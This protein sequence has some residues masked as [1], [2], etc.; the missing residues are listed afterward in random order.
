MGA[1][2]GGGASPR[3]R[4]AP[5]ADG[6]GSPRR[7]VARACAAAPPWRRAAGALLVAALAAAGAA[8]IWRGVT[9][10]GGGG[11]RGP[12]DY[13]ALARE[14]ESRLSAPLEAGGPPCPLSYPRRSYAEIA[15]GAAAPWL[16]GG[17]ARDASRP[18]VNC[19]RGGLW[20]TWCGRRPTGIRNGWDLAQCTREQ[21]SRIVREAAAHA[22]VRAALR[23]TPC[24]FFQ[25]LRGRTLWVI[26]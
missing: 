20:A 12:D 26:G 6:P 21:V 7:G 5:A 16:F 10:G 14:Y 23:M 9:A 8:G 18:C 2:S 11:R 19:R 15:S 17:A 25:H 22:D 4:R 24:D 13:E 3:G 1:T